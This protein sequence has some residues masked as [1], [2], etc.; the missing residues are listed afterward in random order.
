MLLIFGQILVGE[1]A[2]RG[3]FKRQA[4]AS[5]HPDRLLL[6]VSL[7]RHGDGLASRRHQARADAPPRRGFRLRLT[8]AGDLDESRPRPVEHE[9]VE[10]AGVIIVEGKGTIAGR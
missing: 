3:G 8:K 6:R 4:C 10:L 7:T 5:S 2:T 1:H 9:M